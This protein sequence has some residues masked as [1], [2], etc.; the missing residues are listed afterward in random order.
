MRV[1]ILEDDPAQID[2][3]TLWLNNSGYNCHVFTYGKELTRALTRESFDL[4]I[5]DWEL[6]DISGAEVLAW[7]RTNVRDH[8]P[9]VFTTARDREEDIAAM[10]RAG[11]DDYIVKPLRKLELLARL[12]A[13]LRRSRNQKPHDEVFELK[14][15]KVN[16]EA[17]TIARHGA[18][19]DLTQKDF[20]LAVFL[21]RN[22]GRLLSR[23]HILENVWGRSPNLNTRTVD[24]HVSRLRSKLGLVPENGWRLV[25]IYQHGYRLEQIQREEQVPASKEPASAA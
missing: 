1:A 9:V 4:F 5:L 14:E 16:V 22:L 24:T 8:A 18:P 20:D 21:F 25:A 17:R 12:D 15:F 3:V 13:I 10:L 23:G 11:A 2:L 6:P 7:I 19:V